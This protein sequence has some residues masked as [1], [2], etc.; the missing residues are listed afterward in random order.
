[1][2]TSMIRWIF[3]TLWWHSLVSCPLTFVAWNVER[4]C[5][6]GIDIQ[7]NYHFQTYCHCQA[8]GIILLHKLLQNI[9]I[10]HETFLIFIWNVVFSKQWCEWNSDCG[11]FH[12]HYG[13]QLNWFLPKW[14]VRDP[15]AEIEI[16]KFGGNLTQI[17]FCFKSDFGLSWDLELS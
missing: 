5:S 2:P 9:F 17:P 14:Q 8:N 15:V 10:L 7:T 16:W 3:L 13:M 4:Q 6:T 11:R 12:A 1:M